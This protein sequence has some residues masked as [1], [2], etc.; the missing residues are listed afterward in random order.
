MLLAFMSIELRSEATSS[1]S[2]GVLK[3]QSLWGV[4]GFKLRVRVSSGSGLRALVCPLDAELILKVE[5][6]KLEHYSPPAL[7]VKYRGSQHQ[8]S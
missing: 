1:E 2:Y 7:Q 8:S 6:R 3:P 4:L 5:T